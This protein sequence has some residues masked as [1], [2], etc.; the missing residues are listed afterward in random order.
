MRNGFKNWLGQ[1]LR[2]IQKNK[3]SATSDSNRLIKSLQGYSGIYD[4]KSH[5]ITIT[6]EENCIIEYSTDLTN[7]GPAEP[8]ICS[9]GKYEV[10]V[11]VRKKRRVESG[12]VIID[13]LKRNITLTS[14]SVVK[15]YDGIPVEANEVAISGDGLLAGD[16]LDVSATGVQ[17]LVGRCTNTIE[18]RFTN[19]TNEE[20]YCIKKKEGTLEVLDRKEKYCILVK[21]NSAQYK[22]DGNTQEVNGFENPTF[23]I[24]GVGYSISGLNSYAALK[25]VGTVDTNISGT[26][27]VSDVNGNNVS[28]QFEATILPG[29]LSIIPREVIIE[30]ASD[31]Q[32]YNGRELNNDCIKISGDGFVAGEEPSFTVSGK[33]RIVGNSPNYFDF[34]FPD[35]ANNND[36]L[37][38]VKYGNL[39]VINR[40]ERYSVDIHL[41]GA[42]YT[43]DANEH[44]VSGVEENT[45]LI[46]GNSFLVD[47]T[48]EPAKGTNAGC[49]VHGKVDEMHI[50]DFERCDVSEQFDIHIHP[51]TLNI[52]KRDLVLKSYSALKEYDGTPL[53]KSSI[54]ILGT[55]LADGDTITGFVDGSQLVVGKS[56]NK[57]S[58]F[59]HKNELENNYDVILEEGVLEVIDRKVKLLI[60]LY[61]NSAEYI[62]DGTVHS[63]D[64][65]HENT[66]IIN[67]NEY[68]VTGIQ[69]HASLLHTGSVGTEISGNAIITD[70]FGNDVSNQF[71]VFI[72]P[73]TLKIHPRRVTMAS[74]SATKEYDGTAL[75]VSEIRVLGDGFAANETP[76]FDV[77]GKQR[78]VG[79]CKNKFTYTFPNGVLDTDYRV[80]VKYGNLTICNRSEKYNIDIHMKG[81]EYIYDA[82]EHVASGAEED[83]VLIDGNSYS[84]EVTDLAAKGINAGKYIHESAAEVHVYDFEKCD[85]TEQFAIHTHPGTLV[86]NMRDLILKSDSAVKEYDGT[87]L[88]KSTIQILGLGLAEGD[89]ITAY[90]NGSQLLVGKS[91]NTITYLFHINE[92][93]NNYSI[94]LEEGTLEVTERRVKIPIVLTAK[95]AVFTYD[96]KIHYVNELSGNTR[97]FNDQVFTV[98]GIHVYV[99]QRHVGNSETLILGRPVV[100]DAMDNVVSDQFSVQVETGTI[101]IEPRNVKL[102]SASATREYNGSTLKMPDIEVSGDGFVSGDEPV[103]EV[104]GEQRLVGCSANL[105][106][107]KLP[108]HVFADDYQISVE[109]GKLEVCNRQEKYEVDIHL[110]GGD[111]IYDAE[112]HVVSGSEEDHILV[113]GNSFT[114]VVTDENVKGIAAGEYA[115][116]IVNEIRIYDHEQCDVS[117]QFEINVIPGKLKINQ[118]NVTITSASASKEYDGVDLKTSDISITGEGFVP[119][120]E[121]SIAVS[122]VRRLVG[123]SENTF[124]VTWPEFVDKNN[125]LITSNYGKLEVLDRREKYSVDIHLCDADYLFDTKEHVASGVVE[126]EVIVNGI[127]FKLNVVDV[128]ATGTEPGE[129]KHDKVISASVFDAENNDVTKQFNFQINPGMLR[130][131]PNPEYSKPKDE[132]IDDYDVAIHNIL[133]R[134]SGRKPS[135]SFDGIKKYSRKELEALYEDTKELIVS[136]GKILPFCDYLLEKKKEDSDLALL[137]N[138]IVEEIQNVVLLSEI[139][140]NDSEYKTLITYAKQKFRTSRIKTDY[141]FADV[142][143]SVAM[144]QIGVRKYANNYWPQVES[145][146]GRHVGQIERKWLGNTVTKTLLSLGKPVYSETEYVTN[147]LMHC[148]VTD[149]YAIRFYDYLFSYYRLDLER[150]VSGLQKTDINYICDS[151]I[152]PYSKRKQLLSDYLSMSIRA[153]KENCSMMIQKSLYMIDHSFWDEEINEDESLKGRMRER[154]NEWL[155]QSQFYNIEKQKNKRQIG[156]GRRER[157]YRTPHLKVD[158][159][160]QVFIVILPQQ[161]IPVH[162]ETQIPEVKWFIISKTNREYNCRLEEGYSGFKT[163]EIQFYVTPS[164]IFD[165]VV[166][167]LFANK[168]LIR[169]FSWDNHKSAFFTDSLDWVAGNKLET[170]KVYGFCQRTNSIKSKAILYKGWFGKLRYYEFDLKE[171]DFV[172]VNGEDNYY[173]GKVPAIGL[174]ENGLVKGVTITNEK[175]QNLPIYADAPQLIIQAAEEQL[176]G[177]AVI[178]NGKIR[179]LAD[180]G[181]VDVHVGNTSDIKYY[182][183]ST[184]DLKGACEGY[185]KIVIDYPNSQKQLCFEYYLSSGF[186]YEFDGA[187]YLYKDKGVLVFMGRD[188]AEFSISS[189]DEDILEV[190]LESE[191]TLY[192]KVPLLLTSWDRENWSYQKE[193][194]IWHGD[195]RNM[196]YIRYPSDTISLF[197]DGKNK[198]I[199]RCSFSVMSD[200]IFNCDLTKLKSYFSKKAMLDYIVFE[201]GGKRLR[202]LKVVLKSYFA[203]LKLTA[204]QLNNIVYASMKIVGKNDYY[205]DLYCEDELIAEKEPVENGKATFSDIEIETA[206]YTVKLYESEG[207]FGF[208][209]DYRFVGEKTCS[210]IN[211]KDL[212]GGRMKVLSIKDHT[213]YELKFN[214][215]YDYYIFPQKQ[216]SDNTYEAIVS[217]VF[218]SSSV[219]YAS[220]AT[221]QI[222]DLANPEN[223]SVTKVNIKGE[224]YI[225]A[226]DKEKESII[227][228]LI[229]QQKNN[230]YLYLDPEKYDWKVRYIGGNARLLDKSRIKMEET[231]RLRNRPFTIW[232]N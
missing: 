224:K 203:G 93:K 101:T 163:K 102:T 165:K 16:S 26:C 111:Y 210:L 170:G 134:M 183:I 54:Q 84:I 173:V 204:D 62:Y 132:K 205:A 186:F 177:T 92:Q 95:S 24:N 72:I 96:G 28:N 73:G 150:D 11:K 137:H 191:G 21:C 108:K 215:E 180:I 58:Y 225:L 13:I 222:K 44:V 200:G 79:S 82:I 12:S 143:F 227:D 89:R 217:G 66:L 157:L 145:A 27:I 221:V 2:S 131:N 218:R 211:L 30:S 64:G 198:D 193:P 5:S 104:I 38:S 69:A 46:D 90:A 209:D 162:E 232:K 124:S 187:P 88:T 159:N 68:L 51:G 29:K 87:P 223:V 57:I 201:A 126:Q 152:N 105:F 49:Y 75:M 154:F 197:V 109:Y 7:W 168:N 127:A 176:Q 32:E 23:S 174:S 114:I 59:F 161:M 61:A 195:F 130:I 148:I 113:D 164:E 70:S 129:Y 226:F 22:Y 76:S 149:P 119:G 196:L 33:Q 125:Y 182:F 189:L 10:Y 4:G 228:I 112:E 107:Y 179:R 94:T 171:G 175:A 160:K 53:T 9:P 194:D 188:T 19:N 212:L 80:S 213:G 216:V 14:A 158:L 67:E 128:P 39:E 103:F 184:S 48:D 135:E 140:I 43:Y 35:Y 220:R 65:F 116:E 98:S 47:I 147:I 155:E 207:D 214:S 40:S 172:F 99:S 190:K 141:V 71:D 229:K 146:L 41:N 166:F 115:H 6:T 185:N 151:I 118:R 50:N 78:L 31:S 121:P 117:E 181:F 202:M 3:S 81:G 63:V 56:L 60:T 206:D 167:L 219:M 110:K 178:I 192:F 85:V 86:I 133:N 199:S 230:G 1:V 97:I 77:Y 55:G 20:N 17:Q 123:V 83:T 153:D 36:Y 52:K 106:E 136:D 156:N 100:T 25:H 18:Y 120:E 42:E 231:E 169:S 208:D 122:G 138:R 8:S 45:V 142:L 74:L 91:R 15:E 139:E 144:I 34:S 37:I